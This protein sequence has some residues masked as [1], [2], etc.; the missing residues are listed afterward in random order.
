MPLWIKIV[1]L[2]LAIGFVAYAVNGLYKFLRDRRRGYLEPRKVAA[3]HFTARHPEME[4]TGSEFRAEEA[5]RWVIAVFYEDLA[6]RQK[7]S[8]YKL[9]SVAKSGYDVEELS[10]DDFESYRIMGRK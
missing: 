9:L 3:E 2:W 8:P 1:L 5:S 4:F 7:P 6:K 10:G